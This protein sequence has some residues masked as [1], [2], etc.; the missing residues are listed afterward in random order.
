MVKH[1]II[2]TLKDNFSE[3]EKAEIKAEIKEGLEGLKGKI[4][5]LM[6][7][8]VFT[9]GLS[10]SN[11]DLMLDSMFEDRAALSGYAIHPEHVA[12]A[13]N[14]VRPYTKIRSCFDYEVK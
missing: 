10:S 7:I 8:K 13:D 6:G 12:V 5:G 9:D 11:G 2:W 4:P 14:K 3:K 1:V